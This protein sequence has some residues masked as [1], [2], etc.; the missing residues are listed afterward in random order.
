MGTLRTSP[1]SVVSKIYTYLLLRTLYYYALLDNSIHPV[2][3]CITAI[4]WQHETIWH[5][6]LYLNNF[7]M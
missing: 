4:S 3:V 6:L 2:I 5:L 1:L 7:V